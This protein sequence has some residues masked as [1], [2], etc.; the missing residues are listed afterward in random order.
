MLVIFVSF[1]FLIEIILFNWLSLGLLPQ[2]W[3][4]DVI[5]ILMI[6]SIAFIFKS[7]HGSMIYLSLV[8]L[9]VGFLTLINYTM[10]FELN[11]EVFSVM[12]L[13]YAGEALD[14]FVADF[15]HFDAIFAV[16][17]IY[18][19]YLIF[20]HYLIKVFFKPNHQ[21]YYHLKMIPLF[22][23]SILGFVTV[24]LMVVPDYKEYHQVYNMSLFRRN[25][26]K[27]YG[28]SGFYMK[29]LDSLLFNFST[30]YTFDELKSQQIIE[31][32]NL[33]DESHLIT[34][35]AGMFEGKNVIT[36]MIESAQSFAVNEVLTPNLYK[37]VT[38]GLYFPNHHVENKTNVSEVIGILGN[39]P[40]KGIMGRHFDYD[41]SYSM[42]SKLNELGY[43]T[44][45]FHENLASFYNREYNI[46]ELGFSEMY[47]HEDL[48][49]DEPIYGWSG[50]YTLDSRTIDRMFDFMFIE[51]DEPFYYFWTTLVTHGPYNNNV[52]SKRGMN[53]IEKFTELGYFDQIDQAKINGDWINIFEDT[54]DYRDAGR[55]RFYQATMMDF[56]VALGKLFTALEEH[57]LIEDTVIMLYGDH[58]LFYHQMHLR[59]NDVEMGE[60]HYP[61]MY[62]TFFAIYNPV[63]TEAYLSNQEEAT[64]TIEKFVTPYDILPTYYHLLGIPYIKNF[65]L[66]E[67]VFS[68]QETIF[69]SHKITA[70]FNQNYFTYSDDSIY[71]PE[72]IDLSN[73]EE[74]TW[75]LTNV[76]DLADRIL[77]IEMWMDYTTTRKK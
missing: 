73:N 55:Y 13:L 20:N 4:V 16:V 63:L 37:V 31:D 70:F 68:D 42:P 76:R 12:H 32:P 10:N 29:E 8:L 11:G 45:F 39:Y 24:A 19:F 9:V 15:L 72:D 75:F 51:Q 48:F 47:T 43:R 66:G 14:V 65:T 74:A 28:L 22:L 52:P 21:T 23:V 38:E 30:K 36:I 50:D 35:Y 17:G 3:V 71:Y 34:P 7:H 40:Y 33:Y 6:G 77:W 2:Y 53:N 25:A 64:H 57:G 59:L 18:L 58:N 69:Y 46:P 27:K 44:V 5:V 67:S 56:D 41:F 54:S 62:E 1:Y 49:P 61:K 26:I 60:V